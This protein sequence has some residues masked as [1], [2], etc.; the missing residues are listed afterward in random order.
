[1]MILGGG[2]DNVMKKF[3]ANVPGYP[4]DAATTVTL[5]SGLILSS[6][7]SRRRST[8]AYW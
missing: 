7:A 3:F 4:P 5:Y 1:M 6:T 2:F 8:H